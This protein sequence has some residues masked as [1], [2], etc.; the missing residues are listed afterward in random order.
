MKPLISLSAPSLASAGTVLRRGVCCPLWASEM[1]RETVHSHSGCN[2]LGL[3]MV[4][5]FLAVCTGLG[6]GSRLCHIGALSTHRQVDPQESGT[7]PGS[8]AS[9]LPG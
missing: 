5:F 4:L 8:S 6:F 7:C 9:L 1:L 2:N 3:L